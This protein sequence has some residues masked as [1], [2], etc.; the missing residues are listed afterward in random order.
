MELWC[1]GPWFSAGLGSA[2]LM[3][4]LNVISSLNDSTINTAEIIICTYILCVYAC[5]TFQEKH[6]CL[7]RYAVQ[8]YKIHNS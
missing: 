7:V 1:F 3:V 4:G 5:V 8:K 2:M 6:L